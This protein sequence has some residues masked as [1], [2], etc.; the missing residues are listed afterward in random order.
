MHDS[1][2]YLFDRFEGGA[3]PAG[4]AAH[5]MSIRI[6]VDD[7]LLVRDVVA[8]MAARPFEECVQATAPLKR[9]IGSTLGKGW[10]RAIDEAMGGTAGCTHLR[11]L[12]FNMATAAIQAVP[13]YQEH[14]QYPGER[15]PG[16][17]QSMPHFVDR[18]MSWR[19]TGPVVERHYPQFFI[20]PS[21]SD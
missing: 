4:E 18:C 9:L 11:E 10:R 16:Q 14:L 5:D 12:L 6:T 3:L 2:D 15:N 8:G 17:A 19:R 20:Q 13:S 21:D 7:A 1:R